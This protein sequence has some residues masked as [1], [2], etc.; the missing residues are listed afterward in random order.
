LLVLKCALPLEVC[1]DTSFQHE[2]GGDA[3]ANPY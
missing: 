1:E 3:R 2:Q